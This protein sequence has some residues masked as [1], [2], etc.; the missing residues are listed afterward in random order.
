MKYVKKPVIVDAW[1]VTDLIRRFAEG[2]VDSL[3]ESVAS[4]Y[5]DGLVEFPS[6]L[7]GHEI[8]RM[9]I[10]TLEGIMAAKPGWFLIKG[11]HGE[12]YP[13]KGSIFKDTY[14]AVDY[15]PRLVS[16]G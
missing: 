4:A 3:P 2:G 5:D 16:G 6:G 8:E 9:D 13:C 7:V 14:T 11:V 12:M 15:E 10:I 1:S